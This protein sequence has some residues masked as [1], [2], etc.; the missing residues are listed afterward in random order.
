MNDTIV[1]PLIIKRKC[2]GWLAVSPAR[3]DLR[4]GAVGRT[5]EEARSNFDRLVRQ[6]SIARAEEL[7]AKQAPH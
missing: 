1:N 4:I 5:E 7:A 3:A 2:G 6:W